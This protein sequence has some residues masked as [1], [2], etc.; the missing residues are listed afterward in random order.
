MLKDANQLE[1][2]QDELIDRVAQFISLGQYDNARFSARNIVVKEER[3]AQLGRI[4]ISERFVSKGLYKEAGI[5][6]LR[7]TLYSDAKEQF[8]LSGD[9]VLVSLAEKCLGSGS[10][11]GLEVLDALLELEGNNEAQ[12]IIIDLVKQDL[13]QI[14]KGVKLSSEQVKK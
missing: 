9:E 7:L 8:I 1:L 12:G 13:E 2:E 11:V 10:S 4:D 3:D 14:K 5:A 6:F